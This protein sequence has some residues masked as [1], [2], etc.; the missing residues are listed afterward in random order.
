MEI[1][2]IIE[3]DADHA[4]LLDRALRKACFRTN[5]AHDGQSGLN[6]VYRLQPALVVLDVMLP[7]MDG[8]EVCRRLRSNPA[9]QTIPI[10][11]V[12]ALGR[13]EHRLIGLD[14]GVDDYITKP[15]SPREVV[16]RVRA[17]LRR[18]HPGE[19]KEHYLG[20]ELALKESRFVIAWRG[21]RI[22]LSE[23]E[24]RILRF[25]AQ[26][27]GRMVMREE[28]IAFL[29][30]ED[31]LVH[32]HELD[33]CIQALSQKLKNDGATSGGIVMTP[34]VAGVNSRQC[35]HKQTAGDARRCHP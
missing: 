10:I 34:D 9:T 13:E 31:G 29:W 33:R 20:G 30:G 4:L 5:V 1:I 7:G 26:R 2:Q 11:M 12:S 24:W 23:C 14:L 32:E 17:V 27:D 22:Q 16:A 3:D 8:H 35:P 28:I 6:D 15:F 18:R 21:K 25:L 19:E